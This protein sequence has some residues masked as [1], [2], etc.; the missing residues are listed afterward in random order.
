MDRDFQMSDPIFFEYG[1]AENGA[2]WEDVAMHRDYQ[3]SV[4]RS[5]RS[6]RTSPSPSS[7]PRKRRQGKTVHT[8]G[9]RRL[10][11]LK[12]RRPVQP[13]MS[14][15]E[16]EIAVTQSIRSSAVYIYNLVAW[17]FYLLKIPLIICLA[18]W[19]I[20]FVLCSVLRELFSPLCAIPGLSLLPVCTRQIYTADRPNSMRI[21]HA[22]YPKMVEMQTRTFELL[23]DDQIGQSGLTLDVKKAEMATRDLLQLVRISQLTS[24]HLLAEILEEFVEDARNTGIGLSK[25]NSRIN[26][27]VDQ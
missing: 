11:M 3:P 9:S 2:E 18:G 13:L 26:G 19:T 25:L 20:Y 15:A 7:T 16:A 24:K 23:L 5:L 22:D 12:T 10:V 27:A 4:H 17:T 8:T 6:G 1:N 14:Q 21:N